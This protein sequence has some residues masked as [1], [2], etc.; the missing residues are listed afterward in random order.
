M[1]QEKPMQEMRSPGREHEALAPFVGTFRARVKLWM[2]PGDPVQ[3]SGTMTTTPE[4]GGLFLRQEYTG[5]PGP[6]PFPAFEGHGF[7]GFN[8]ATRQYEGFWIDNAS[9]VMQ[10]ETGSVDGA[11]KVWTM[12]GSMS[13]PASGEPMTK[14]SVITLQD[15]DRHTLEMFFEAGGRETR[16]MEIEYTRKA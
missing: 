14:R 7:W 9:S 13:N 5:D 1:S 2:G 12:T 11:G 6:S 10:H 3:S 8:K 16:V 4:L 15:R